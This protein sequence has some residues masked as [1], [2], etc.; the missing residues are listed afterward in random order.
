METFY[1]SRE[2]ENFHWGLKV[3]RLWLINDKDMQMMLI[4]CEGIDYSL[5]YLGVN[6]SGEY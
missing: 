6:G 1:L 2:H 4:D 3:M 5:H